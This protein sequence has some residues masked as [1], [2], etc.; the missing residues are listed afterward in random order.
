MEVY[1]VSFWLIDLWIHIYFIQYKSHHCS[2]KC[3][4]L[5]WLFFFFLSDDF[6]P[7]LTPSKASIMPAPHMVISL[8]Y[9]QIPV[10]EPALGQATTAKKMRTIAR[11][12]VTCIHL[13]LA[14]LSY[15]DRTW[16]Y[17]LWFP[18]MKIGTT[19]YRTLP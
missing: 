9:W 19:F 17:F 13:F 3:Y 8:L 4:L 16:R 12:E 10:S 7:Y 5:I 14:V 15:S 18:W 2:F 1:Q 6:C 11:K